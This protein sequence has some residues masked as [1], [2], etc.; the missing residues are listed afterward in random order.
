MATQGDNYERTTMGDRNATMSSTRALPIQ[1]APFEPIPPERGRWGRRFLFLLV[2]IGV[3]VALVI[4][5]KAVNLWPHLRNPF[6]SQTT[7]RSGPVVLKS[8][9]DL[10]RYEAATGNFQVIVD[11]QK[12]RAFVPDVIF[13]ERC[14]F[15]GVGSVD[16]FVDFA[17][18][19]S[20]AVVVSPD[21]KSV[22]VTLPAP[23]LERPNLDHNKSYTYSCSEGAL[24]RLGNLFGGGDPNREMELLQAAD[25]K[26]A[27]SAQDSGLKERA[28]SNTRQMLESLLHSLGYDN[29]MVVFTPA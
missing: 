24:N 26:I 4:G 15:V 9:Q 6:A 12:D 17:R 25:K 19:G 14:L 10:S 20:G 3:M 8:I 29:V 1:H 27:Q 11:L 13:G 18:I 21:G 16:A 28:E 2:A 23:A 22:T 7:D 5:L